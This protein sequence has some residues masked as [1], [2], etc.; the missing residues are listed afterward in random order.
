MALFNVDA[1]SGLDNIR[2]TSATASGYVNPTSSASTE[3][4]LSLSAAS[5]ARC[6]VHAQ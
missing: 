4:G 5:N 1:S 2:F 3:A 6:G